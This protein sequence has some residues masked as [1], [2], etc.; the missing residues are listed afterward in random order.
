[1]AFLVACVCHDKIW[2]THW[3]TLYAQDSPRDHEGKIRKLK[4][5]INKLP[6]VKMKTLTQ[7]SYK[8]ETPYDEW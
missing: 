8:F 2:D 5:E 6:V 4:E 3:G 7:M 1:M